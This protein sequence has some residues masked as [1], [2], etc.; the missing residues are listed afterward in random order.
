MTESQQQKIELPKIDKALFL[1]CVIPA[2]IPFVEKSAK[3]VCNDLNIAL[4]PMKGA[5]CC[6]DPIGIKSVSEDTWRALS[7]RNVTVAEDMGAKAI[8]GLCSGCVLSL[9]TANQTMKHDH[10]VRDRVNETLAKIGTS[11]KG[12]VDSV[13]HM[14]QVVDEEIGIE[15]IKSLVKRPLTG[16]KVAVHYGCHFIRPSNMI[17]WDDP[18]FPQRLEEIVRATGA[19]PVEYSEKMLCCG[20]GVSN[21]DAEIPVHMNRRKYKSMQ[22]AGANC[23][24]VVCPSCYQRLENAQRDVAKQFGE[25]Y[26]FPV[27]YFTDLLALSFGHTQDEIGLKFHRPSPKK[28]LADI[29]IE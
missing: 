10:H 26:E 14:A 28:L 2:R 9:K 18:F 20:T 29:G 27:F 21:A 25:K 22:Q 24:V 5:A 15:T 16:L 6:P 3:V 19:E 17:E 4:H 8:M 12:T 13:R 23:I 11:F 1:G 7:A